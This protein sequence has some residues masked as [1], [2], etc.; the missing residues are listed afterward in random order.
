MALWNGSG[1]N[2]ASIVEAA[3]AWQTIDEAIALVKE[4]KT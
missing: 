2:T 1:D 3:I 4:V